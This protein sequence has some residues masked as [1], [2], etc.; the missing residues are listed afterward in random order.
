VVRTIDETIEWVASGLGVIPVPSSLVSAHMPPSVIARP[1]REV[2][3]TELVAV[4][5]PADE[6]L[7]H[8]RFLIRCVV[9]ASQAILPA[10]RPA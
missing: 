6:S 5:W 10:I 3:K 7:P 8:V 9:Q 1:L 2:P 4:W